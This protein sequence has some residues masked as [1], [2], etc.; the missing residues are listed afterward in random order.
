[1]QTKEELARFKND[2]A[3]K[4]RQMR[5]AMAEVLEVKNAADKQRI[6]DKIAA[7]KIKRD[8]RGPASDDGVIRDGT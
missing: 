4:I 3:E 6:K 7:D 2:L 1:M 8:R 5:E